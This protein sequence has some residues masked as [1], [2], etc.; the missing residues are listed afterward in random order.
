MKINWLVLLTLVALAAP[1]AAHA[2]VLE[3]TRELGAPQ[4]YYVNDPFT[5]AT[6]DAVPFPAAPDFQ[7]AISDYSTVRLRLVAPAGKKYVSTQAVYIDW[8]DIRLAPVGGG[9]SGEGVVCPASWSIN[10]LAGTEPMSTIEGFEFELDQLMIRSTA[11]GMSSAD[12]EF[13]EI[14]M[15]WDVSSLSGT[16]HLYTITD[17]GGWAAGPEMIAWRPIARG[18]PDP[19]QAL[20]LEDLAPRGV[21]EITR[22][23]GAPQHFYDNGTFLTT[24]QD[25]VPFP[26]APNVEFAIDD[27]STVRLRLVAP[28]GK[29]YVATRASYFTWPSDIRLSPVGGGSTS[30]VD[31]PVSWS[32]NTLAGTAPTSTV[33][34]FKYT[35]D[36]LTIRSYPT[37]MSSADFEFT[38]IV[39]EWD[40][41]AFS[42]TSHLYTITD[43]GGYIA[44]PELNLFRVLELGAPDTGQAIFLQDIGSP[45][46][47]SAEL[48]S[49]HR[50]S[51]NVPNPFNPSTMI[52]YEIPSAGQVQLEIL[53]LRGRLVRTLVSGRVEAGRHATAWH[54]VGDDGRRVAS[55]VYLYRLRSGS[56]VE[57][58]SM[59]LLK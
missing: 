56:F 27:Y 36:W 15:E 35:L 52:Y 13:T 1:T 23:L 58:R 10:T 7:F 46:D 25:A 49:A 11:T 31:C 47:V 28:A 16:S 4:H 29:K 42:G 26:A 20:F 17:S 8:V 24:A 59:V 19:G 40:V 14:V 37:G 50:L 44:G 39:L 30:G 57:T 41:S 12:F 3:I 32:I 53:D 38:E 43:D 51:A 9:G 21:L 55:G 2:Q 18:A 48:P 5:T 22:E 33:A 54:G 6:G 34:G 45:S